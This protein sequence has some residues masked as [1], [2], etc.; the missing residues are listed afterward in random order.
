MKLVDVNVIISFA[1][2]LAA[3]LNFVQI[4]RSQR[5]IRWHRDARVVLFAY[6]KELLERGV[7]LPPRC[8]YCVQI[9]PQHVDGC[10]LAGGDPDEDILERLSRPPIKYY[11]D[12]S[13]PPN[14]RGK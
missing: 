1:V 14:L 3:A 9:L 8:A 11:R 4:F 2:I 12:G 6:E 5:E 7:T 10:I 13:R